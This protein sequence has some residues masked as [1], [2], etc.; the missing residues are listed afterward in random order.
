MISPTCQFE[1]KGYPLWTQQYMSHSRFVQTC[2]TFHPESVTSQ[3][4]D[5]WHQLR[6]T[7]TH[8]NKAAMHLFVS[9]KELSFS[10]GDIANKLKH[11]PI[12]QYNNSKQDK[13]RIDFLYLLMLLVDTISSIILIFIRKKWAK[14]FNFWRTFKSTNNTKSSCEWDSFN[15]TVHQS[16]WIQRVVHG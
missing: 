5:K 6:N 9:G 14:N 13:F 3:E 16:R 4:G 2:A 8:L 15:Q 12:R 1:I 7:I 11:N 10:N